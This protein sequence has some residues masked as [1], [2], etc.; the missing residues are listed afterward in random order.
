MLASIDQDQDRHE[1]AQKKQ[2][3]ARRSGREDG[4]QSLHSGNVIYETVAGQS[5]KWYA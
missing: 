4:K 3:S 2:R 1:D 5:R